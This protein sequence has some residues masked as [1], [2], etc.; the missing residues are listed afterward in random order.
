M[1]TLETLRRRIETIADLRAIVHTMRSL[2]AVSI[3]QYERA[4]G[5]LRGYEH[6]VALG[7]QALLQSGRLPR[8]RPRPQPRVTAAVVFGSDHGLCGRFNDAVARFAAEQL[9]TE[10]GAPAR[11]L[12]LAVGAR[13]ALHLEILGEPADEV[14][15]VPGSAEGL[16]AGTH[17]ILSQVEKWQR[18]R[19]VT[20]VLL[21]YNRRTERETA[22]PQ[23]VHLLSPTRESI[24]RGSRTPWPSRALPGFTLDPQLLF[25]AVLRQH[26][27]TLVFRAGAESSASEHATRLAALNAAERH[28]DERLEETNGEFHRLR[29]EA[30]TAELLDLMSGFEALRA[31]ESP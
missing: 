1:A 30:V 22:V 16:A 9:A 19:G 14:L 8:A 10:A 31:P 13:A 12:R 18:T 4:T 24:R 17:A 11:R 29:Q 5:A 15:L 21:F 3:R 2:S 23:R 20:R 26:F 28:I 6:T 25:R 27:F 7:L